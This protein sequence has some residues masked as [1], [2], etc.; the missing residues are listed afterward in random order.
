M[1]DFVTVKGRRYYPHTDLLEDLNGTGLEGDSEDRQKFVSERTLAL[2]RTCGVTVPVLG[3]TLLFVIDRRTVAP[4]SDEWR[5]IGEIAKLLADRC[6]LLSEQG[7]AALGGL[8]AVVFSTSPARAYADV[9]ADC[10][11]YDVDEFRRSDGSLISPSYAAS[12]IVHDANHVWMYEHG[13]TYAGTPAEI[14]CWQLQV[15]NAAALGL[16]RWDA[17]YI[18][19]L[20]GTPQLVAA[21]IESDPRPRLACSQAGKCSVAN[22]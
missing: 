1:G 6:F 9:R 17:D 18:R 10:F 8:L 20:I 22:V 15:D 21:R 5:F 13:Q 2:D 11:V 3:G 14:V 12:N 19:S 16:S 7:Q 4:G